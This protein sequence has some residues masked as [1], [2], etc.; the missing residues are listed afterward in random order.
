MP[1]PSRFGEPNC[2]VTLLELKFH[3]VYDQRLLVLLA[4]VERKLRNICS[5]DHHLGCRVSLYV[6]SPETARGFKLFD[7]ESVKTIALLWD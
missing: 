4:D 3:T 1:L 6:E 5:I 7:S 2:I